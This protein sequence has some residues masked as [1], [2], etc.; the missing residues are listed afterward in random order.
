MKRLAVVLVLLA[1]AI[2]ACSTAFVV[3]AQQQEPIELQPTYI[4]VDESGLLEMGLVYGLDYGWLVL[5]PEDTLYVCGC[6]EVECVSTFV[7]T[8]YVTELPPP[9]PEEPKDEKP[10]HGYGDKNHDHTGPPGRDK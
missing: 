4:L 1:L 3:Q 10:G 5:T 8:T 7:E 2:L 9:P 6:G